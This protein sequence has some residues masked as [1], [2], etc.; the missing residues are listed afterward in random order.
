MFCHF[1]SRISSI[2]YNCI[3]WAWIIV[4]CM[5]IH[6]DFSF[7]ASLVTLYSAK[8]IWIAFCAI[9]IC[10]VSSEGCY[11]IIQF[12][13]LHLVEN[14]RVAL[15]SVICEMGSWSVNLQELPNPAQQWGCTPVLEIT[16]KQLET[17]LLFTVELR[18]RFGPNLDVFFYIGPL[19]M[20]LQVWKSFQFCGG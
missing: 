3:E 20:Q 16:N 1:D 11:L 4:N 5:N 2:N 12:Y 13:L 10:L 18:S 6:Q 9:M 7:V 8:W 19:C 17:S 14:C 15:L